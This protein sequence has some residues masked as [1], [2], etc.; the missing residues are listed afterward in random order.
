MAQDGGS[1]KSRAGEAAAIVFSILATFAIDAGWDE[2]QD[3]KEEAELLSALR[4]DYETNLDLVEEV[5]DGH[6]SYVAVTDITPRLEPADY[7]TMSVETAARLVLSLAN[8]VVARMEGGHTD[9]SSETL[10]RLLDAAGMKLR[11]RL[12]DRPGV[13][14]HMLDDVDRILALTPA[15]RLRETARVDRFLKTARRV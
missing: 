7:D 14:S 3:R 13:E 12:A 11:C 1:F 6:A 5:I 10:T 15:E 2:W 9:P 8:P 4:V